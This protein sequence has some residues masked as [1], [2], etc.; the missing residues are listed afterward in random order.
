MD[1][2]TFR[3]YCLSKNRVSESFPFDEV[4]LV[5]KVAEKMFA[6]AGLDSKPTT[7]NLK[8]EPTRAIELREA[9]PEI[10]PGYHMGKTHWN[11]VNIGGNLSNSL[12]KKLIDD[13]YEL[14]LSGISKKKRTELG[15]G[16]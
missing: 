11:T 8:C 6:L 7:V 5:F 12:I 4:T 3:D 9:Y 13:S 2:E 1:I 10:K 15:L 14:V 16:R